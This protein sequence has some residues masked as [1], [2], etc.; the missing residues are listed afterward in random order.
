MKTHDN[1]E[2]V[3]KHIPMECLP[4]EYL[5]DDYTGPNVGS[6][7]QILGLCYLYIFSEIN[8]CLF[9]NVF[10]NFIA[11]SKKNLKQ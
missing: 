7:N 9:K 11:T 4:E 5:P 1:L 3:Y 6:I 10:L 2:T 8:S